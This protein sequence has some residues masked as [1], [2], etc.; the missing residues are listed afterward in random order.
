MTGAGVYILELAQPLGSAKHQA[1]FYCGYTTNLEGRLWH[2]QNGRG[3]AFT[4][5]AVE[6]G[7][8]FSVALWL[9][10]AGRE[11]ERAI[12]ASHNIGRWLQA[13]QRQTKGGAA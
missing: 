1:R 10:G 7:I 12:K 2:H 13:H 9:P 11:V 5:A 4:R 6:R 8:G 3:A